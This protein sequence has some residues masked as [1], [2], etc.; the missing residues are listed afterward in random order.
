[1]AENFCKVIVAVGASLM[2]AGC[3]AETGPGHTPAPTPIQTA[4]QTP[5][6]METPM[7][8][9]TPDGTATPDA[10][11]TPDGTAT[12][13]ASGTPSAATTP[14]AAISHTLNP[15]PGKEAPAITQK[16]TVKF[17]T[18]AGEGGM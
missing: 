16:K 4:V 7:E 2:L 1:M 5:E 18:T 9:A 11:A 14:G 12:P 15:L 13:D 17:R 3:P 6:P 10:S 8:T